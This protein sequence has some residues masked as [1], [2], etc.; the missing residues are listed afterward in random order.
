[1]IDA[2]TFS[3]SISLPLLSSGNPYDETLDFLADSEE[4]ELI[5]LCS[6]PSLF[7]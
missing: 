3:L 7:L 4:L 2:E 6:S 5:Y 1:L